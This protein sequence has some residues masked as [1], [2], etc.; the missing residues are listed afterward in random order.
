[1][2]NLFISAMQQFFTYINRYVTLSKAEKEFLQ[3][4]ARVRQ[5]P[6]NTHYLFA[7]ELKARWC[8]VLQGIVI[9]Y[10]TL[11]SGQPL[12]HWLAQEHDYFT[13][14]KHAFSRSPAALD[15]QFLQDSRLLEIAIERIKEA[16]L[17]YPKLAEFIQILK[18]HQLE[19]YKQVLAVIK[20]PPENRLEA[21]IQHYPALQHTLTAKQIC[22]FLHISLSTY[23]RSL[24]KYLRNW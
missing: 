3:A 15:I 2:Q 14:T 1:M 22:S 20:L 8:F 6:S 11:E 18:Q 16:Q 17:R 7:D 23:K 12:I 4:Y 21:F 10:E 13:D 5:Y 9:G 19:R 24:R